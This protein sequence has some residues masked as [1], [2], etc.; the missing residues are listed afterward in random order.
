VSQDFCHFAS[1]LWLDGAAT[2]LPFDDPF[3]GGTRYR[4]EGV[5]ERPADEEPNVT[6][7]SVTPGYFRA[8][9]IALR[10]GREFDDHDGWS[11]GPPAVIV[12]EAFARHFWPHEAAPVSRRAAYGNSVPVQMS[13]CCAV[14]SIPAH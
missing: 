1:P 2:W 9:G 14:H 8:M 13:S 5:P 11:G 10:S 7:R 6:M 12:N 3:P 4:A